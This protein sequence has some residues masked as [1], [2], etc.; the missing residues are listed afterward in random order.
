[1]P[2]LSQNSETPVKIDD[3][4]RIPHQPEI[5]V[6]EDFPDAPIANHPARPRAKSN[7]IPAAY[8]ENLQSDDGPVSLVTD[9]SGKEHYIGPSGGLQFLG[10]LRR[11]LISK[12]HTPEMRSPPPP[13]A[14]SKFTEDDGAQA[15]EAEDVSEDS[16]DTKNVDDPSNAAMHHQRSPTSIASP[17]S[18][19]MRRST[20]SI[21]DHWRRLPAPE[22]VDKLLNSFFQNV[23][24]DF[25]LFHRGTFEGDY[26]A[27][28]RRLYHNGTQ[29]HEDKEVDLGL[30]ACIHMMLVFGSMSDSTIGGT[31]LDHNML[32]RQCV[33]SARSLL[34]HLIGKCTLYNLRALLLLGLFLHNNNER[35]ATWN[36]VGTATRVG[37]ALGLHRR[38]TES[39][40]NPIDREIRKRIFCTL[41]GFEQ[42][43]AT[44]LGR[45]SGMND[46]DVEVI[47]PR[48]G[49]C[50]FLGFIYCH[51]SLSAQ[52]GKENLLQIA[53]PNS[54]V[55]III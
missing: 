37:F 36:L 33:A 21:E 3:A 35:N 9:T 12:E 34:P 24:D 39:A 20:I 30:L 13:S 4:L 51:C 55:L 7:P 28:A 45:P 5:S 6:E 43:L 46:S 52:L 14:I 22:I 48:P 26:E 41:Y 53:L 29:P 17:E 31:G 47:P 38:D 25:V 19:F 11:L 1:M 42:F 40:F 54:A 50:K 15:L 16:L 32:R 44:S 18:D 23:H 27:Q 10:Q 2:D 8:Q 49:M